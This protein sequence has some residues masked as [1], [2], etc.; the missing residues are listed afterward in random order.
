MKKRA[1]L[2]L[3]VLLTVFSM[4]VTLLAADQTARLYDEAD[5]LTDA[6]E[7]T[8]LDRLNGVSE[9]YKVDVIIATVETVGDSTADEFVEDFY[10]RNGCGYGNNKDGVILLISM[11][12]RDYRI[13]SNGLGAEAIGTDDIKAIGDA[14]S[15][16]LTAGRYAKA[17]GSF[18]DE[19]EYLI[20][21]EINGFPFAFVKNLLISVV[22]GFLASFIVTGMMRRKLKSVRGQREA[23]DYMKK[24]S[25]DL[26]VSRDTFL[27]RNVT[28]TKKENK[29]SSDSDR[30]TGGGKF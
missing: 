18:I 4:S 28:R 22:I 1:I 16:D 13:L 25:M 30:N 6:E 12:E 19:C 29:S 14:I 20:D 15:S 2:I 9:K 10:D 23:A 11:E 27:Y 21:G 7:N 24:G 8:I 3:L 26:R 17:F 5:L